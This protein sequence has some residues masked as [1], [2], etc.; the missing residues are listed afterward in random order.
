MKDITLGDYHIEKGDCIWADAWSIHVD[1][2]LW[3][4]DAED[5]CP[6]R[7]VF[8]QLSLIAFRWLKDD[9]RHP[10]AW[11]PFGA[12]PRVC[13]GQRLAYMEAKLALIHILRRF[14]ISS[15]PKTEVCR[16]FEGLEEYLAEEPDPD[17]INHCQP[18]VRHS[19]SQKK[20]EFIDTLP[21]YNR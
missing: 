10:M 16:F 9:Q 11:I 21:L 19:V 14:T 4:A 17:R 1:K 8:L 7:F 20:I 5:F 2:T 6:E 12:G 15:G 3:G 18:R 13:I